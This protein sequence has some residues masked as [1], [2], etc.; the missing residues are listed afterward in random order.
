MIRLLAS[1]LKRFGVGIVR[2]PLL[3]FH[4]DHYLRHNARRLEHLASLPERQIRHQ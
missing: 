3:S 4:S 1:I 2:G